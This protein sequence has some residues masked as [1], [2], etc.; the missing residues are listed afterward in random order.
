MPKRIQLS[1]KRGWRLPANAVSVAFPTKY[2]N[3]YRLEKRSPEA[4]ADAVLK[5]REYLAQRPNLMEAAKRELQG[6]DLAC[7]CLLDLP[8]HA[9][10]LLELVNA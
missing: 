3:S 1:R 9:D 6:K 10:V 4:N 8:C 7:W 5:Y 2:Q